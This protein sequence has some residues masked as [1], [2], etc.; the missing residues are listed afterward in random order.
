MNVPRVKVGIVVEVGNSQNM[1]LPGY[2][3][4]V[5]DVD[6]VLGLDDRTV[7]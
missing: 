7:V 1:G 5:D 2:H 3:F 4:N 6:G